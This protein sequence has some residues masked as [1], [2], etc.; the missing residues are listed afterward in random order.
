MNKALKIKNF[1]LIIKFLHKVFF[2]LKN[3]SP[4]K[5]RALT[6][7]ALLVLL[8]TIPLSIYIL[9]HAGISEAAWFNDNWGYRKS[10]AVSNSSGGTLSNFQVKILDN[11]DLSVDITAGKIK[12]DLGD[13]RFT[14]INGKLLPYWIEDTTASSVDAW[15]LIP[16]IPTSGATIY[17]YYG[18]P[19]AVNTN[20]IKG[21]T[22]G[23][24][25]T[26][27]SGYRIHT[28]INSGTFTA[29]PIT[30]AAT[31]VVAGGGGGGSDMAGGGGGGGVIY[32]ASFT[33]TSQPYPIT[34]GL[35][36]NG[37]PAG[38]GQVRGTNGQNS[39]FGT[40]TAIGGGGGASNHDQS[41][42]PAGNGGSGGG[43]SGGAQPPN[44]GSGGAG[45]YG[46]GAAGTGASGQG[47][48]GSF[49][50]WAW[51]PGG[52][53]GAGAAGNTNPANGGIGVEN[54][55]LGTSYY[56]G[57]GGG[58]AGYSGPGG[59]GGN[60]GGGGGAVGVTTG[61][62]GYNNGSP[63]TDGCSNCWAN[64]PGGNAGT[65][66][67]GGG[68]GGS[69][70]NATNNGGNGGSGIVIVRYAVA[71]E[72][73]AAAPTNE[74]KSP[75]PVAYWKFDEGQGSIAND[76][77]SN[78]INGS[79][80]GATW[81]TE[82]QCISG[83]CLKFNGS[84]D[85]VNVHSVP[86]S[87]F[88]SNFTASAWVKF[89]AVNT[90]N[91]NPIFGHGTTAVDQGMHLTERS[92]KAYMGF[93]GDDLTGNTT[94]SAN[95][96]YFVTFVYDGGKKIYINGV[97]DKSGSSSPYTG[98]G[99]NLEIGRYPWATSLHFNG[100]IDEPKIYSYARSAAQVK[101]D[102][103]SHG[104]VKGVS[105]QIGGSDINKNLS[106]GLVGYWKMDEG[107][108]TLTDSS[109]NSNTGTWYGTGTSHYS[110]GKF[111]NGGG[112]NGTD[113]YVNAGSTLNTTNV[114]IAMWVKK[115]RNGSFERVLFKDSDSTS[116]AW[117][118]QFSDTNIVQIVA[119]MNGSTSGNRYGNGVTAITDF[120]WHYIVGSYDGAK[121][122]IYIDGALDKSG[123]LGS[124]GF[125]SG[126]LFTGPLL[127]S[128]A[129]LYIGR[130]KY[131][132]LYY[133][134]NATIDEA[135][136]YN[137]ALS[138]AE[139]SQLYNY[140]PS[141]VAYYNFE[142][143]QGSSVNDT[144][145]NGNNG[146]WN[147]TGS[148]WTQGKYGKAGNFN[149]TDDYVQQTNNVDVHNQITLSAWI[150]PRSISNLP[151]IVGL[152]GYGPTWGYSLNIDNSGTLG[153]TYQDSGSTW[154]Y[155]TRSSSIINN[156]NI[157]QWH[158]VSATHDGTITNYYFDGVSVGSVSDTYSA[159]PSNNNIKIGYVGWYHFNGSIDDVKIYNYIRTAK[160]IISD[161]NANH[162]SVGSPIGSAV[163]Y[164][165]FDEGYGTTTSNSG[166]GGQVL[167]GTLSGTTI[168]SWTN[169][170]KFGKALVFN[171]TSSYVDTPQPTQFSRNSFTNSFWLNIGNSALT[172]TILSEGAWGAGGR[173]WNIGFVSADT[174][175]G[176]K[177]GYINFSYQFV[178]GGTIAITKCNYAGYQ[179]KWVY[180]TAVRDF[181]AQTSALYLNGIKCESNYYSNM[182]ST[183]T[184]DYQT[185]LKIGRNSWVASDYLN[186]IVDEVKTYSYAL[187]ADEVKLDYN[188]GA[189]QVLGSMSDTL[190]L[191]GGSVASNSASAAY[192]IPGDTSTCNS[193]VGEWN[194][195]E[196]NGN[197]V[198]DTSGNGNTG[199]WNGTLNS[200]WTQGKIGKAGNF[201][202]TN[203]EV[204]TTTSFVN[205]QDFS[206]S[207][208]F[209]TTVASGKNIVNFED[210]QTGTGGGNYDRKIYM[211]TDGKVY[212]GWYS[213]MFNLI[214]ST[215][216]LTDGRW[217]YA[218]GTH[219][220]GNVGTFYIDGVLQGTGGNAAQSYTGYWR[221]GA[222]RNA[223]W[224][225]GSDGYFTGQ[226]DSVKIFNYARTPAQVAWDYNRGAP[227]SWW[228]FDE[229][230]GTTINDSSGNSNVG[231]I[232]GSTAP[233]TCADGTNTTKWSRGATGKF[234]SSLYF[235]GTDD[236]IGLGASTPVAKSN[237]ITVTAWIKPTG[238][239]SRIVNRG[240]CNQYGWLMH[241][242]LGFGV[243][244][245]TGCSAQ[246]WA[247]FGTIT[248][249]NW[250]FLT[251]IF[252]GSKVY[253]YKNGVLMN[254]LNAPS[255]DLS[256]NNYSLDMMANEGGQLDEVKIY[257]YVL[258]KQQI[259]QVMNQGAGIRFGPLTGSP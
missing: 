166:N 102:F 28:F 197:S 241:E 22:T 77:S 99:S 156:N 10:I 177:T 68:G 25:V 97:L 64:V 168:P 178:G 236:N 131:N 189:A 106:N 3:L 226:I 110:A 43:A 72:P 78:K 128:S 154:H 183:E 47:H 125:D 69:H 159:G 90:G 169:D 180:I 94:F 148:H 35:G 71:T 257:N 220:S 91:D 207:V 174:W 54:S 252:D 59:S 171:G 33:L 135:R 74:E 44:G 117:G 138:P 121:G 213:G 232:N 200:Q 20:N 170:G 95:T 223:S 157:N 242:S 194:F 30:T 57:G 87:V 134:A 115:S 165:K 203:N 219:T 85:Y 185:S 150:K 190:G 243:N 9:R 37:A 163:G 141:P 227:V 182:Q 188:H 153:L 155:T 132:S 80:T 36:G 136:I 83:K 143:G 52:G 18:N 164:W 181:D 62:A 67:G 245:S 11:K 251:G 119:N 258:T 96:W 253:A 244:N 254:Q 230:Q 218:V 234:N 193:P 82:D 123:V 122:Y 5:R 255:V 133:Y 79:I 137:R 211:G 27:I 104:S 173:G 192:C 6:G 215:G 162:P 58:G 139:V 113:D 93:Y 34:V 49:G 118:L 88:R 124:T 16:T 26:T 46:G 111:G 76:S 184:N 114:T 202:G 199:T 24:T 103:A 86:D 206:I 248:A 214:T 191:T 172:Q 158:Y 15:V 66:T 4:K 13:L 187:T 229:C 45:G 216:T 50:I 186:G 152:A 92:G 142:E 149:G 228:K 42:N 126:T 237:L 221:I 55:I 109:G 146:T 256:Q 32:N 127:S 38:Q 116:Q 48:D 31:L 196:G 51:Y 140:A 144:S 70:Y 17:M 238:S 160:Q 235:N 12:S 108:G 231:T 101:A 161:M 240:W 19:S 39:V 208:W 246:Y 89:N 239:N 107:S 147:G 250:Y 75:G 259:Q 224:T 100:F 233:G 179:N 84:S 205:P 21:M 217:H 112:F 120:N 41:I 98:T 204:T 53:G 195:E 61:G 130:I 209:K 151:D 247:S 210:A 63:G 29:G 40:L 167:K 176:A 175:W 198:N 201:N 129:P 225:N 73:S 249:G 2:P 105:A 60:G 23:G 65:N 1:K 14:D 145:G 8:I 56:W 222:Y 81:Q 7:I 212:F